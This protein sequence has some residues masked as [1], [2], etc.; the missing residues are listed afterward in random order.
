MPFLFLTERDEQRQAVV[1]G[2]EGIAEIRPGLAG[3]MNPAVEATELD[4]DGERAPARR[5]AKSPEMQWV[6][7]A[8]RGCGPNMTGLTSLAEI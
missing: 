1:I 3:W 2:Q 6:F 7:Q 4:G 8:P 5:C